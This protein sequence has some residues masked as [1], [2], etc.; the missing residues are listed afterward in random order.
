MKIRHC[1]GL[2]LASLATSSFAAGGDQKQPLALASTPAL[3]AEPTAASDTLRTCAVQNEVLLQ[4]GKLVPANAAPQEIAILAETLTE[5][6]TA[7]RNQALQ[8]LTAGYPEADTLTFDGEKYRGGNF[9]FVDSILG[10]TGRPVALDRELPVWLVPLSA[11]GETV[12]ADKRNKF[13]AEQKNAA[14]RTATAHLFL[15][16]NGSEGTAVAAQLFQDG[17]FVRV[18]CGRFDDLYFHLFQNG[19]GLSA[20]AFAA[21]ADGLSLRRY[22]AITGL[23]A[24]SVS[25]V[26]RFDLSDVLSGGGRAAIGRWEATQG[27]DSQR[28]L[29]GFSTRVLPLI[30]GRISQL[31]PGAAITVSQDEFLNALRNTKSL[32]PTGVPPL[33]RS[34]ARFFGWNRG[35]FVAASE[36]RIILAEGQMDSLCPLPEADENAAPPSS[37]AAPKNTPNLF[38]SSSASGLTWEDPSENKLLA[39][40]DSE[41]AANPDG[42]GPPIIP[43]P[44]ETDPRLRPAGQHLLAVATATVS[45][46]EAYFSAIRANDEKLRAVQ[47]FDRRTRRVQANLEAA[48]KVKPLDVI[49]TD[50]SHLAKTEAA[51][52]EE[53]L[54]ILRERL[55]IRAALETRI[56]AERLDAIKP[57]EADQRGKASLIDMAGI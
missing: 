29:R 55:A 46:A 43:A 42:N 49:S 25:P 33:Y 35:H 54:T 10:L 37:Q 57:F 40:P 6:A 7:A 15:G 2:A 45:E 39:D 16:K 53:R 22:H 27:G 19:N 38:A 8:A 44:E 1:F 20:L 51:L 52:A 9:A 50:L 18:Y 32:Y 24:A 41:P 13:Q 12:L 21:V 5:P 3:L 4:F 28:A 30:A 47:A 26:E 34:A 17:A 14:L 31:A 23:V 36:R 48:Q 11:D 56:R